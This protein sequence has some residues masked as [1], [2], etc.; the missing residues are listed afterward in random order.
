MLKAS[1]EL[2][3]IIN[4]NQNDEELIHDTTNSLIQDA[5]EDAPSLVSEASGASPCL[6]YMYIIKTQTI[7][8]CNRVVFTYIFLYN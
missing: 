1:S 3:R 4:L 2:L 6:T 5:P 7:V 8:V